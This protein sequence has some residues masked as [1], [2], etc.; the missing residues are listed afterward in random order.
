MLLRA[1]NLAEDASDT[2]MGGVLQQRLQQSWSP[3][4]F[5]SR[6]LSNTK[7][8][9]SA[10]D[11]ELLAAFSAIRHFS[12][13]LQGRDFILFTNHNPLTHA[14]FRTT[15]PWSARQQRQLFY[16]S[17]F[18][19]NIIHLPGVKNCLADALSRPSA[20]HLSSTSSSALTSVPQVWTSLSLAPVLLS[21]SFP[22]FLRKT[23]SPLQVLI[24]PSCLHYSCPVLQ[25]NRCLPILPFKYCHF[26]TVILQSSAIS[27]PAPSAL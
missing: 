19:S 13:L 7:T 10:F 27:P 16:I 21:L 26:P 23:S 1:P 25:F 6:K 24:S 14:L 12:F 3:L 18:T 2:H 4:A 11:R 17:E 20:V 9:Y 5:F 15:P 22:H 8:R